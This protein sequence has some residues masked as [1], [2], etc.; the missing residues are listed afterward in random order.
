MNYDSSRSCVF[1]GN[2]SRIS[3]SIGSSPVPYNVF[4]NKI[5]LVLDE[6]NY[7]VV[8]SNPIEG[9]LSLIGLR[10]VVQINFIIISD[11]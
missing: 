7:N 9:S 3:I 8:P 4:K 5:S 1:S 6:E 11:L 10:A 2:P